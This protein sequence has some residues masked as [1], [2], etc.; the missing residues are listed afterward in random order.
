MCLLV[1]GL[2]PPTSKAQDNFIFSTLD[3]PG[4]YWTELNGISHSGFGIRSRTT[5]VGTYRDISGKHA[6]SFSGGIFTT[7]PSPP[8]GWNNEALGINSSGVIVGRY[9]TVDQGEK[10]NDQ[11][12][13]PYRY[14]AGTLT[15]PVQLE[16]CPQGAALRTEAYGINNQGAIVGACQFGSSPQYPQGEG[17]GLYTGNPIGSN[18]GIGPAEFPHPASYV[19]I[20]GVND[21][22][23]AVGWY[24]GPSDDVD[25]SYSHGFYVSFA[26]V[27]PPTIVDVHNGAGSTVLRGLNNRNQI[28]GCYLNHGF[29]WP[30]GAA[31]PI[32]IDYPGAINTCVTG[33]SDPDPVTGQIVLVGTY[34]LKSDLPL[35]HNVDTADTF[36]SGCHGFVA[37]PTMVNR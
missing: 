32:T 13:L 29:L 11:L 21:S 30:H 1:I 34:T 20:S 28:V 4:A 16:V 35:C 5:N 25:N 10:E 26:V 8:G 19:Y 37:V 3:K 2:L 27:S 22:G 23:L 6:F 36:P 14:E 31:S 18:N 33:I 9:D 15:V 7:I 17:V 12:T 24:R